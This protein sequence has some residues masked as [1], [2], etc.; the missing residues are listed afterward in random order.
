MNRMESQ[1]VDGAA[2]L[3]EPHEDEGDDHAGGDARHVVQRPEEGQAPELLVQ[4]DSQGQSQHRLAEGDHHRVE[5]GVPQGGEEEPFSEELAVVL[6]A[7]PAGRGE[8]V[9]LG[10]AEVEGAEER[11]Q[12]EDAQGEEEGRQ[13]QVAPGGFPGPARQ[14]HL[15]ASLLQRSQQRPS[16]MIRLAW[17]SAVASSK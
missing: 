5:D 16:K 13:E 15:Q 8:E 3:E 6:Q 9:I 12:E 1:V 11:V 4:G 14:A 7:D 17:A 2:P 10:E